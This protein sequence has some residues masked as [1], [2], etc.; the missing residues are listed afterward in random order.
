A[1]SATEISP[2]AV[3]AEARSAAAAFEGFFA[4]QRDLVASLPPDVLS[5]SLS[6]EEMFERLAR[7]RD[8]RPA[9]DRAV[10]LTI[11][12]ANGEAL[13]WVGEPSVRE[14]L[15]SD[16]GSRA[17]TQFARREPLGTRLYTVRGGPGGTNG[18]FAV[19]EVLLDAPFDAEAW[20]RRIVL[21]ATLSGS[22]HAE[23]LDPTQADAP[24]HDFLAT[25]GDLYW[26]RGGGVMPKLLTGLH[27]RAGELLGLLT[28]SPELPSAVAA[29]NARRDAGAR[30]LL[31]LPALAVLT[32][33]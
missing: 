8:G 1:A 22:I 7:F 4:S 25:S 11:Y 9:R 27:G 3:E 5:P 13:A 23:F 20:R 32:C 33:A 2:E 21:P 30:L 6:R 28:L 10:D 26:Q 15:G 17:G 24:L 29:R 12:A 31:L 18:R 14:S 19:A 16:L